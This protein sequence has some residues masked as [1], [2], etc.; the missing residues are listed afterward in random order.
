MCF[1]NHLRMDLSLMSFKFF[2][3]FFWISCH[4]LVYLSLGL[5][6]FVMIFLWICYYLCV[7][8]SLVSFRFVTIF[9]ASALWADAFY[10]SKFPSVCLCLSVCLSL[11]N[12]ECKIAAQFFF[13]ANLGF[14]N[15]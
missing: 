15:H 3:I 12:K 11:S 5:F 2:T 8:L 10:K 6:R 1:C 9:K 4:L 13:L 7:Y 14:I